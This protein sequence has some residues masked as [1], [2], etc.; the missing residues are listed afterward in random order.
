MDLVVLS[1]IILGGI[2]IVSALMLFLTAKKFAVKENPKIAEIEE[3]LPGANCGGCGRSGCHDFAVACACAKSLEGL[4]CPSSSA[5]TMARIASIVGLAKV[6]PTTPKVAV[7]HCNGTCANRPKKS[8][9][10]GPK[11][12]HIEH[13]LYLGARGCAYGCLG[14]GD[15]VSACKFGAMVLNP[16]K[17]IVEIDD[18]KCVGCGAC[19]EMCPRKL[20]ELRNKGPRGMRVYV[21][22]ANK[23]KGA[24]AMKECSV[25]CI[26]CGKCVKEC[27]HGAITLDDNLA[28]IDYAK[29]KLCKKCVP[30]C[31][32]NAIIAVNF[33]VKKTTIVENKEQ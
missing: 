33:P 21:A 9:Y 8:D 24:L 17:G 30:V 4:H 11:S 13:S 22:C 3:L 2:G 16:I 7:L 25:S 1:I 14:G 20:I 18:E 5:E 26:G 29:C 28:Y 10:D 12:C 23:D 27:P 6:A 19:V 32:R 15:C 31:P